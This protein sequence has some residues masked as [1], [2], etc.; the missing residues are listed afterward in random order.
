MDAKPVNGI[1]AP[2]LAGAEVDLRNLKAT[3]PD[4]VFYPNWDDE[5]RKSFRRET[6]LLFE[7][8]IKGNRSVVDLLSAN[9]TFVNERLARH[10]GMPDIHGSY[11]RRVPLAA[12]VDVKPGR[13]DIGPQSNKKHLQSNRLTQFQQNNCC[14]AASPV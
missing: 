7:S 1:L 11:F 6:E 10:Y 5:L 13:A 14:S 4:G 8:V 2:R 9:Y 12:D 3:S